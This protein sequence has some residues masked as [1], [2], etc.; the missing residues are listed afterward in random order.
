MTN[1]FVS[2]KIQLSK[3]FV[4]TYRVLRN[5]ELSHLLGIITNYPKTLWLKT[6]NTYYLTVPGGQRSESGVAVG[7]WLRDFL[8]V[9]ATLK[10]WLE[11]RDLLP[12]RVT[13]VTWLGL[14]PSTWA[15]LHGA[16]ECLQDMVVDFSLIEVRGDGLKTEDTG[17]FIT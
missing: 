13:H 9:T 14:Q 3:N 10:L 15:L 2:S 6:I 1:I 5:R 12:R 8:E 17:P 11:L 16:A 7:F 4:E